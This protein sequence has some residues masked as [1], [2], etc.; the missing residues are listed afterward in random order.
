MCG[1]LFLIRGVWRLRELKFFHDPP[2]L[3]IQT[4]LWQKYWIY[5]RDGN[6]LFLLTKTVRTSLGR[7]AC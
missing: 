4:S 7:D 5:L 6:A 3:A 1:L 2:L